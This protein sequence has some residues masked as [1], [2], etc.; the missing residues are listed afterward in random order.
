M[1][2][3]WIEKGHEKVKVTT[4]QNVHWETMSEKYS[5]GDGFSDMEKGERKESK[6]KE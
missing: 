5:L 1:K 2:V 6:N 4:Y 3:W